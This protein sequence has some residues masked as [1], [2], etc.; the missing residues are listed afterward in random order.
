VVLVEDLDQAALG[1]L[2]YARQLNPLS[3]TALHVVVDPDHAQELARLW[4]KVH[5]PISLELVDAPDRNLPATVEETVA[6]MVRPD[7]EV[8]VLV[9]RRRFVGFWRRVLHDQTSAELTK[10]LGDLDN[11]NVTIVPFRLRRRGGLRPVPSNST[12]LAATRSSTRR[13]SP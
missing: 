10:V 11:V 1:A 4:A 7:T 13:S 2:Q 8:T 3:I 6:E 5:I 9:P 12:G